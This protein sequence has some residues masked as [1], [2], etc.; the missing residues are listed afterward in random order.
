MHPHP[1]HLHG[2]LAPKYIQ[3]TW[4]DSTN[5]PKRN[6]FLVQYTD[7]VDGSQILH[8]L[9]K[10]QFT[11]PII[12]PALAPSQVVRATRF[13]NHQQLALRPFS[14]SLS[15]PGNSHGWRS[16]QSTDHK[17]RHHPVVL[18]SKAWKKLGAAK[19]KKP[20]VLDTGFP[21]KYWLFNRDPY[22]GLL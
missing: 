20:G 14:S 22:N 17:P 3:D 2:L 7:T 5:K 13:L 9:K 10:R 1:W 11:Y 4:G 8:Q 16:V 6:N 12:Y 21:W 18:A 19:T 15:I